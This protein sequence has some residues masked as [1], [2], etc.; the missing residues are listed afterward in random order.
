MNFCF[1]KEEH[2]VK[3][4]LSLI[5]AL[6]IAVLLLASCTPQRP[7][8]DENDGEDVIVPDG[9]DEKDHAD[10]TD[11]EPAE[12][13]DTPDTADI[14][15]PDVQE[16]EPL[17]EEGEVTVTSLDVLKRYVDAGLFPEDR[18]DFF[19][20][21]LTEGWEFPEV[22][23][24]VTV[25]E[26]S[27]TFDLPHEWDNETE[28]RFHV[29]ESKLD[30]LPVGDYVRLLG[31]GMMYNYLSDPENPPSVMP[32]EIADNEYVR[33]LGWFLGVTGQWKTPTYGED[34]DLDILA[35][36]I[37][38]RYQD[39]KYTM[40]FDDF[41]QKLKEEFGIDVIAPEQVSRFYSEEDGRMHV[42]GHGGSVMNYNVLGV[43]EENGKTVVTV[44]YMADQYGFVKSHKV[45]YTF[46]EDG[47]WLGY[48]IIEES[49]YGPFGYF[50]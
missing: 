2:T 37:T 5:L 27:F 22:N 45:A 10:E 4:T 3:K 9:G 34:A 47:K 15:V 20:R 14:D 7:P 19:N 26:Y 40:S 6:V 12:P 49:K 23:D 50:I 11:P 17:I 30:T 46:S 28:F 43:T 36:Y 8:V 24:D 41:S 31:E 16:D 48:E 25:D 35:D 21:F 18:Y 33:R 13:D 42:Q 44:Q 29:A 1:R 39:E 38:C 32:Q